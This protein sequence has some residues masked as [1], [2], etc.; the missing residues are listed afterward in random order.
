MSP[1]EAIQSH[2]LLS[3]HDGPEG[4]AKN[5]TLLLCERFMVD[6][7]SKADLCEAGRPTLISP[8]SLNQTAVWPLDFQVSKAS[9]S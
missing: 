4:P 2:G 9:L 3:C 5:T 7:C 6:H 1:G 8:V